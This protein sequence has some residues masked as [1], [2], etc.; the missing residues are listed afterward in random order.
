MTITYR[1]TKGSELT[2]NELDANFSTLDT[3]TAAGWADLVGELKVIDSPNSP[4]GSVYKGGIYAWEFPANE[5][6]EMFANF[7]MPHSWKPGTML[8]PHVHFVTNSTGAGTV[9]WV[10]E[11]TWARRHDSSGQLKFQPTQNLVRE[12]AIL[13]NNDDTHFVGEMPEGQGIV[14]TGLEVDAMIMMRIYRE[15][16]HVN[17]TFEASVWAITADLHMEVD[18]VATP[19][20]APDFYTP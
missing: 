1:N 20:R 17:D 6:R 7:H 2:Y 9:R 4:I 18:R 10:F 8:Y 14:A 13:A 19:K 16:A 5:T 12:F 11:Y 3:R 15:G